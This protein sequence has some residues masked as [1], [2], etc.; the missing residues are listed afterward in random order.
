MT[1]ILEAFCEVSESGPLGPTSYRAGYRIHARESIVCT[2]VL[3]AAIAEDAILGNAALAI[4]VTND[5]HIRSNL[6]GTTDCKSTAEPIDTLIAQFLSAENLRLEE[7][8]TADLRSMLGRL[9]RSI[10][11]VQRAMKRHD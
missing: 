3:P 11:L 9:E 4:A 5:G 8:T 10:E 1:E 7:V 6:T 2:V